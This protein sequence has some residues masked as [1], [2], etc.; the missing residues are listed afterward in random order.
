MLLS[1]QTGVGSCITKY[2]ERLL[3]I[4]GILF[5]FDNGGVNYIYPT[6]LVNESL[7]TV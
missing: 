1:V 6:Q 4:D 5:Y 3:D 7:K 2:V